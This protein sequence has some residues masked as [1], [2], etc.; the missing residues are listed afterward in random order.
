MNYIAHTLQN[1]ERNKQ[2]QIVF[3]MLIA[4]IVMCGSMYIYFINKTVWNV[5]HRQNIESEIATLNSKLSETEFQYINSVSGIT[6]ET[7]TQLGFVSADKET[8]FV[9]REQIGKNVAIR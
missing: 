9:A 8:L 7:A 3:W 4:A 2:I 6:I 5:V 1:T